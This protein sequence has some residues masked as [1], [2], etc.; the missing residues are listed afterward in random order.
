[1]LFNSKKAFDLPKLPPDRVCLES[2]AYAAALLEARVALAEL[3]GY[4][5]MIPNPLLLLSP[6]ILRESIASSD[7]ENIQTTLVDAL[8]NQ[9]LPEAERR[10]NDKEVLR[11]CDALKRGTE[12]LNNLP[13]S[14][15]LIQ[16]V[17]QVLLP[18]LGGEYRRTQNQIANTTT[19]DVLYTP[20]ECTRLSEYMSNWESYV[21]GRNDK[22]DPL[23]RAAVAHYQFEAIHPFGDGNGRC[24]RI[25]I[26]LHLV[27]SG[28]LMPPILYISGFINEHRADYYRLLHGVTS[29]NEW[30]P[31]ILFMLKA[32]YRQAVETRALLFAIKKLLDDYK[33]RIR[34]EHPKLYSTELVEL[35][36]SYPI[37][38]PVQLGRLLAVHY[39]TAS[40][41]LRALTEK[42]MLHKQ[43]V[44]KYKFFANHELLELFQKNHFK[45]HE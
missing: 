3:K 5:Y 24:G 4:S 11:Y 18:R 45:V 30:Q 31:F 21:N 2:S 28:V 22:I 6:A 39:S 43:K 10:E 37:V 23:I 42:G 40:R 14:T 7:I 38:T 29:K 15:R 33:D 41:Y 20:P 13:P 19:G 36:F 9:L 1:M 35:L 27:H 25:L 26:V 17:H 34:A 16:E 32:F 44:G 8:R 12:L